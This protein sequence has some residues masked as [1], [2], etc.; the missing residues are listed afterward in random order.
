MKG[1]RMKKFELTVVALM[2]VC[3]LP[4]AVLAGKVVLPEDTAI[5]V[6]FGSSIRVNSGMLQKGLEVPIYL[7]EDI[8]IGG[9]TIVEEGAE[10]SAE[11]LEMERAS[12]PGDP[13]YI[14][15]GFKEL[16]T[17][18]EYHTADGSMIKLAGVAE[19]KGKS[20]K[21]L[22]WVF[23]LGLFISGGEGEIDTSQV[24]PARV[25]ETVILQTD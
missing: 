19:N 2:V 11:V 8:T 7:A 18:G 1:A 9:K 17:R 24:Y 16:N 25:E 21:V 4:A 5:K 6:K 10:G 15:L 23:I 20:R 13:G 12:R 14:K 22:S 3:L